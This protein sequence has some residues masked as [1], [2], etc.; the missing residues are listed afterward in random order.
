MG[1]LMALVGK[2]FCA[3]FVIVTDIHISRLEY[4]VSIGAANAVFQVDSKQLLSQAT[5]RLSTQLPSNKSVNVSI[6]CICVE[7]SVALELEL[8]KTVGILGL[9]G[10]SSQYYL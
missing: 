4:A 3:D 8:T 5:V 10:L 6:D 9:V 7:S 2:T 1:L